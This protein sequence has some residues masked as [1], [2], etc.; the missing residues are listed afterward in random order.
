M[1]PLMMSIWQSIFLWT[2]EIKEASSENLPSSPPSIVLIKILL[3]FSSSALLSSGARTLL[4]F[5]LLMLPEEEDSLDPFPDS[6][7]LTLEGGEDETQE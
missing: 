7:R 4:S 1:R 2:E 5:L 6:K 3:G